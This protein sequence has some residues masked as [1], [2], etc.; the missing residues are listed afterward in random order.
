MRVGCGDTT[1]TVARAI[2]VTVPATILLPHAKKSCASND[3]AGRP[4][5]GGTRWRDDFSR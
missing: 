4:V 5:R 1:Y 3:Q 2:V